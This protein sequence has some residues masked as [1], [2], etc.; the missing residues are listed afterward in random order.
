MLKHL[1]EVGSIH[2]A[3]A[4]YNEGELDEEA[5]TAHD[6]EARPRAPDCSLEF[7]APQALRPCQLRVHRLLAPGDA[8][9]TNFTLS[10][11][12]T[13]TEAHLCGRAW[14]SA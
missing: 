5:N 1:S 8:R 12:T 13:E 9:L 4:L 6:H 2:Q 7:C 14:G 10:T 3:T 11:A